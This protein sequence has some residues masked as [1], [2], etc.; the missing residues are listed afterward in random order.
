MP[1]ETSEPQISN[2]AKHISMC[3]KHIWAT[4]W[5]NQ[6]VHP[7]KTQISLGIRPVW[8]E[9][10]L[11]AWRKLGSLATH[12]AHS[13]DSDQTGW[14]PRLIWVFAGH[15]VILLVLLWGGSYND[16]SKA[17]IPSVLAKLTCK[18]CCLSKVCAACYILNQSFCW[19]LGIYLI[20]AISS[21][22]HSMHPGNLAK[23]LN[24]G[25]NCFILA[26][27]TSRLQREP[28]MF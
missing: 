26:R 24:I 2:S 17:V 3:P 15:T 14:M 12:W 16:P 27:M 13:E 28:E 6:H 4:S 5:Q 1:L 21:P 18:W 22:G 23:R 20:I 7:A 8:S 11:S 19:N 9:S 10:L 25:G